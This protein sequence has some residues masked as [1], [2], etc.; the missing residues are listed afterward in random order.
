MGD[1]A[2]GILLAL[3][4]G[5][6]NGSFA[7][8]TKYSKLW[9]WENIWAVWAI[10][11]LLVAPWALALASIPGLFSVY[12]S[13]GLKPLLVI[14][15]FGFGNGLAQ[16]CFGLGLAAIGLSLGFAIAIGLST[17][18]GSLGLLALLHSDMIFRPQGLTIIA[19]VTLILIG[20]VV[21][22]I[23]GHAKENSARRV[24]ASPSEGSAPRRGL[25]KGLVFAVLAGVLSP[26]TNFGLAFGEPLLARAAEQGASTMF[27]ANVLWPPLLAATLVPYLA[28]CAYLWRKNHSLRLFALAGTRHYWLF[29]M[30]M[31]L[32]WTGSLALYGASATSM[33]TMGP[34]LGWP[35]FMSV[36]IITSSVW[37]FATGEWRGAGRRAVTIMLAG[38]LFLILGFCTVAL[39]SR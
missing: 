20:I 21:C 25:A 32:L 14:V 36:I 34:I 3:V 28:Y 39:A 27:Q 8:P 17:V 13:A 9:N 5:V 11:A 18:L 19:G 33:S 23:G 37:G 26:S 2:F 4:A 31:G 24:E 10:V 16:I 35:L 22:A 12:E 1:V 15:A 38:I 6:V 7:A 29:G 30:I